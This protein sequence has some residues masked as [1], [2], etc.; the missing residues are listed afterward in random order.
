MKR[1]HV[2]FAA[3]VIALAAPA[4]F[5]EEQCGAAVTHRHEETRATFC[6]VL[7]GCDKAGACYVSASQIDKKL[8]ANFRYQMRLTQPVGGDRFG[9]RLTAVEP[10]AD[11]AKPL[12]LSWGA[13]KVDLTGG[14]EIRSNGVN[15]YHVKDAA[16]ADTT[17]R[18]LAAKA[19][20]VKW[21]F[22]S[23]HGEE[24][25]AELPV[26]GAD[27]ALEWVACMARQR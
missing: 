20:V 24:V 1:L 4:G 11:T 14:L 22:W 15:E 12:Q 25:T 3:T 16:E 2:A 21:L 19:N 5:S 26:S 8:P 7:A 10:M 13:T 23:A 6:A 18:A 9:L 27:K 17:A